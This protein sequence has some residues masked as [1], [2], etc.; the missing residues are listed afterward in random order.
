MKQYEQESA[1]RNQMIQ[2]QMKRQRAQQAKLMNQARLHAKRQGATRRTE[3]ADQATK[4]EGA[5]K[6][7]LI[8]RGLGNTTIQDSVSRGIQGDADKQ[9][10]QQRDLEAGRISGLYS[11]EAGMQLPQSNFM[12]GGINMQ[13]GGLED[14]IRIL[15]QLGGGL[16]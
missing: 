11:Q 15:Q 9:M 4:R 1:R 16:S 12:M 8:S 3:I 2:A 14:Y 6:Q 5:G 13:S 10:T 7:N